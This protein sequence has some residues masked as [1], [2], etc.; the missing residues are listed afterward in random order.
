MCA[1]G[2]GAAVFRTNTTFGIGWCILVF[3]LE[4][5]LKAGGKYG[6]K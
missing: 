5:K 4:G 1:D 3:L 6:G 2:K